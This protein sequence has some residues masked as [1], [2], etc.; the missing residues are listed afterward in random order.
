MVDENGCALLFGQCGGASWDGTTCCLAGAECSSSG[1]DYSQCVTIMPPPSPAAA[2]GSCSAEF[3]QCGGSSWAGPDCCEDGL[4]CVANDAFYS[5]CLKQLSTVPAAPNAVGADGCGMSW[6]QC[7]GATWNGTSCCTEDHTCVVQSEYYSQ[8]M[9]P[10]TASVP[11]PPAVIDSDG[12]TN[13]W[14]QCG[15][16]GFSEADLC[17]AALRCCPTSRPS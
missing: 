14:S 6:A 9:P 3:G 13:R 17:C 8:C 1:P 4:E 16:L 2:T 10:V 12:C 5:Q 7:G 11:S 15:G